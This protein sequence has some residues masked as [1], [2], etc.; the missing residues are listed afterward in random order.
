MKKVRAI[1]GLGVAAAV[2]LSASPAS[3]VDWEPGII[4][5][6]NVHTGKCLSGSGRSVGQETCGL[7]VSGGSRSTDWYIAEDVNATKQNQM[8]RNKSTG[9]CLDTNGTDV[10]LSGCNSSDDG[11]LWGFNNCEGALGHGDRLLTGWNSGG[12]NLPVRGTVDNV[13]KSLWHLTTGAGCGG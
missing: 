10:Y 12:V 8:I 5:F 13:D 4:G 9:L 11:Q 7:P 3:A 2:M 1:A 6:K